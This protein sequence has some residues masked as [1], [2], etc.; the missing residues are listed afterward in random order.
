M[1][2]YN[3]SISVYRRITEN[4]SL[5]LRLI[6]KLQNDVQENKTQIHQFTFHILFPVIA[7]IRHCRIH[8]FSDTLTR[9]YNAHVKN[10]TYICIFA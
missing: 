8:L 4:I 1:F 7:S 9:A 3:F 5:Y 6:F 2:N 10:C